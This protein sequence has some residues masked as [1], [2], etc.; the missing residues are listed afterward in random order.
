MC[1]IIAREPKTDIDF[2]KIVSA[3]VVNPDG[4][5][6]CIPDR[7]KLEIRHFFDKDGNDPEQVARL[8]EEAKDHNVFLHLRFRT[9]GNTGARFSHPFPVLTQRKHGQ[10]IQLMHN[11]TL[12]DFD[13]NDSDYPDTFHFAG[14]VVAPLLERV[15]KHAG[16]TKVLYDPFVEQILKKYVGSSSIITLIDSY[17][18]HLTINKD[19]G[20]QFDGWWASNKYSFDR[21]YR[22]PTVHTY[23]SPYY[24]P[25]YNDSHKDK[26]KEYDKKSKDQKIID[27]ANEEQVV[28]KIDSPLFGKENSALA[29]GKAT[30]PDY[31]VNRNRFL[32]LVSLGDISELNALTYDEIYELCYQYPE[33]M[34]ILIM[35]LLEENYY[36]HG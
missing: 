31:P 26:E 25:Y 5:G 24:G 35:D 33:H 18:N 8:L 17:G 14:E 16:K 2:E 4:W 13:R 3:C 11:G 30:I 34:A 28:E 9:A 10:Q 1:V 7:G 27:K 23:S 20:N 6:Y 29:K 19:N 12:R 21:A 36:N 22:E 32:D 15:Q